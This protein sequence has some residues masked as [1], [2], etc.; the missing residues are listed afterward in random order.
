MTQTIPHRATGD[1]QLTHPEQMLPNRRRTPPP[2]RRMTMA[3][4]LVPDDVRASFT[5]TLIEPGDARYEGA[6]RV[7]N[8]LIDKRPALV[9]S[10]ASTADVVDALRLARGRDLPIAVRGGGHNVA[11]K[12]TIDDGIVI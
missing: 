7:H 10:C 6:R 1:T 12:A 8:G 5:G 4:N 9:A 2:A 3:A 11:G